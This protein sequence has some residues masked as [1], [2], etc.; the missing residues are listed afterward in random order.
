[1][2]AA[3]RLHRAK[4]FLMITFI[5]ALAVLAVAAASPAA[6]GQPP[7]VAEGKLASAVLLQVDRVS[8]EKLKACCQ[9]ATDG[10]RL[11]FLMKP[12]DA[13]VDVTVSP[14]VQTSVDHQPYP[15]GADGAQGLRPVLEARDVDDLFRMFPDLAARVPASFKP[16]LALVVTIPGGTLPESG[17]VDVTIKLGYRRQIEP[18]SFTFALP[19]KS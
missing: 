4:G 15:S 19:K 7:L 17:Q 5:P 10:L 12:I 3:E 14:V 1:M 8:P 16:H 6:S 9:G 18:F 2:A 13:P 11:I